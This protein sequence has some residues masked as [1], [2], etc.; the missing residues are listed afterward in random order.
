MSCM[1]LKV[2][3][4]NK[5]EDLKEYQNSHGGAAFIWA[6]VYD[7]YAKNPTIPYD[8]WMMGADK[9]WPLWKDK[10][11]PEYMRVVLGSTYDNVIVEFAKLK[12]LSGY[13]RK[14]VEEFGKNGKV[15]HLLDWADQCEE[16]SKNE[17]LESCQGICFY[18]MS[19]SED[20]WVYE[21]TFLDED[22][23]E[24]YECT[25]YDLM[26]GD[27]HWFLFAGHAENNKGKD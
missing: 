21:K 8:N 18:Q 14:F 10:R 20:P 3:K 22:G 19:V 5:A 17:T 27:K 16:I 24:D 9:L 25:P 13:F 12:E 7:R 15:C 4:D 1:T 2:V 6:C 23:E 11:L 26:K